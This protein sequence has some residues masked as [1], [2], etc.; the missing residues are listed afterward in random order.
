MHRLASGGREH[1]SSAAKSTAKPVVAR[2]SRVTV[3]PGPRQL[4][5]CSLPQVQRIKACS[6]AAQ[7]PV[8]TISLAQA[9]PRCQGC[10]A[11]HSLCPPCVR[12]FRTT[13]VQ[14]LTKW[15]LQTSCSKDCALQQL[16]LL[17]QDSA[18]SA[19][20]C[21]HALVLCTPPNSSGK[22]FLASVHILS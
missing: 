17:L 21:E 3:G 20:H 16:H 15:M 14:T 11:S 1:L 10:A 5:H 12:S 6:N 22:R 19:L 8:V 18:V 2:K 9:R 4:Q 7:H 13:L